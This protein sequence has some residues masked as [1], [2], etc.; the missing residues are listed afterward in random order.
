MRKIR[1]CPLVIASVLLGSPA[2]A[3]AVPPPVQRGGP[4]LQIPGLPAV[5][6]PPGTRVF[7]PQGPQ[8]SQVPARP[9]AG[10]PKSSSRAPKAEPP[11]VEAE[12]AMPVGRQRILDELF[13]RL[14][15][16]RDSDEAQGISGAIERVWMRSGSDTADLLMERV[17]TVMAAKEWPLAEELLDRVVEIEPQWAEAWNKRATVR[18]F[19]DDL[20][21]S[22]EDLSH[23]LKLEP[24]HF[25]ALVG[26]GVILEKSDREKDALRVFRRVLEINPQL[27]DI[28]KKVDKLTVEVEGRDI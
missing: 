18:F 27:E 26:M 25:M 11:K 12:A 2:L 15:R 22:M 19:H 21:G 6:L 16:T 3:E 23:V 5:P 1:F 28:R 13:Q 8:S 17:S 7:G 14:G 24:R 9:A 20:S 4:I 10:E